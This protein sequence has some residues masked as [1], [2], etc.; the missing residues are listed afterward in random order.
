MKKGILKY[1]PDKILL[2]FQERI[3]PKVFDEIKRKEDNTILGYTVGIFLT[4]DKLQKAYYISKL[5]DA[6]N[7]IKTEETKYLITERIH[8]LS[9]EDIREIENKCGLK[10]LDG[11]NEITEQI[12]Y[13]LKE[14]CRL[15]NQLFDEK[16]I[17]IISDDTPL[18]EKL[19]VNM[20]RNLRFL[21]IYSKDKDFTWELGKKTLME[22]G[23][24]LQSIEKLDKIL[25]KF[26]VIINM[27]SD[28][29]LD[30]HNIKRGT[31]IIDVSIGRVLKLINANRK[32][33]VII[34]DFMF[35]NSDT[36]INISDEFSFGEKVP[37]YIYG[38]IK[39]EGNNTPIEL[40]VNEKNYK[41]KELIE[42]FYGKKRNQS[43]FSVK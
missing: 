34:T 8:M 31:I 39:S 23:L 32:D 41:I 30:T 27:S 26:D 37:S 19:A 1:V 36:L 24:S 12:P 43:I 42:I 13:V 14:I 21:T 16:E 40:K 15:R 6:L 33:L 29:K 18:T 7:T 20:A 28:I 2:I 4:Y 38:G 5:I 35:K 3:I 9:K 25:Q 22:T 11:R 10:I 17:L